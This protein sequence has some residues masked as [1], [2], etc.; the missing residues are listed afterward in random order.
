MP[1]RMTLSDDDDHGS[2]K[3][4]GG[5]C[6]GYQVRDD[7]ERKDRPGGRQTNRRD[8]RVTFIGARDQ[9]DRELRER[10]DV[11]GRNGVGVR[12]GLGPVR[13]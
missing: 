9:T 5:H 2:G 7:V 8:N 10:K 6:E 11:D 3:G 4:E 12:L 1:C 13:T